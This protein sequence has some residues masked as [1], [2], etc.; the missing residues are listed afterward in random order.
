MWLTRVFFQ[1]LYPQGSIN[2]A[3]QYGMLGAFIIITLC[4]LVPLWLVASQNHLFILDK[5]LHGK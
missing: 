3:I 5:V 1:F 4:Y 2:P